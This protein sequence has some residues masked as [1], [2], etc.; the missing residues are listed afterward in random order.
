[1]GKGVGAEGFPTILV[2][3][4]FHTPAYLP[5][6]QHKAWVLVSFEKKKSRVILEKFS[7][8][9]NSYFKQVIKKSCGLSPPR[10]C[11]IPHSVLLF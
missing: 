8:V 9:L 4:I 5:K 2:L 6:E 10:F 11:L 7:S 3:K 1:M